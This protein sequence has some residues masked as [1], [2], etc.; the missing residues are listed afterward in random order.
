MRSIRRVMFAL[1]VTLFIFGAQRHAFAYDY[2]ADY[3]F[4][5][6]ECD[7]ENWSYQYVPVD[8]GPYRLGELSWECD[9]PYEDFCSS[10]SWLNIDGGYM[11]DHVCQVENGAIDDYFDGI[12]CHGFCHCCYDVSDSMC[13]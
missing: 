1:A 5:H 13:V 3:K 4:L 2:I 10:D 6:P 12:A 7:N 8:E 11:C 9:D